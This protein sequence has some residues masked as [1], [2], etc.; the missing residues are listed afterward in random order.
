MAN[1][2]K[3]KYIRT[4]LC[5]FAAGVLNGA[6]GT[7]GGI[8]LWFSAVKENDTR[9]AFATTAAGVLILSLESV[10]LSGIQT[11][12]IGTLSPLFLF[13]AVV[14]GAVGAV[15]LGNIS[16]KWMRWLFASLLTGSGIY[17]LGKVVIRVFFA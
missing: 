2:E 11:R 3:K 15:L 9:R 17:T 14:G 8:P 4:A 6:L 1:R 16:P 13:T 10:F 5:A 12:V 7:G